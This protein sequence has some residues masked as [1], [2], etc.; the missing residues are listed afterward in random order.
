MVTAD[1]CSL[2]P[3][4]APLPPKEEPVRDPLDRPLLRP[5]TKSHDLERL[6]Y[7]PT[8]RSEKRGDPKKLGFFKGKDGGRGE[9]K[10]EKRYHRDEL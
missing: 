5:I 2:P 1:E 7:K 3:S 10:G 6:Y 8:E 4:Q 9:E